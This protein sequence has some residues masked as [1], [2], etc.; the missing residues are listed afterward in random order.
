[1]VNEMRSAGKKLKLIYGGGGCFGNSNKQK[2][3]ILVAVV[4]EILMNG[5]H[6]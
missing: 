3:F 2:A 6:L 5:R 1:M 4:L